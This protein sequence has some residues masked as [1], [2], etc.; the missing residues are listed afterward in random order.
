MFECSACAAPTT[1]VGLCADCARVR[2]TDDPMRRATAWAISALGRHERQPGLS[3][4]VLCDGGTV[5]SCQRVSATGLEG[6]ARAHDQVRDLEPLHAFAYLARGWV[7]TRD[8]SYDPTFAERPG[9]RA[10]TVVVCGVAGHPVALVVGQPDDASRPTFFQQVPTWLGKGP[11]T[12]PK[13]PVAGLTVGV[14]LKNPAA[15]GTT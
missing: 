7:R 9:A 13:E 10:A 15:S 2:G 1:E 3:P 6:V 11:R 8:F 5:T 4:F 14:R 12:E